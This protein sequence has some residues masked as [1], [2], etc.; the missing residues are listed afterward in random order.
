[1]SLPCSGL[2]RWLKRDWCDWSLNI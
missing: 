2:S 1:M